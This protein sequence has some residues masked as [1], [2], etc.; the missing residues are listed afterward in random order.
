MVNARCEA[1]FR[2]RPGLMTK[3][4]LVTLDTGQCKAFRMEQSPEF[5]QPRLRALEDWNTETNEPISSLRTERSG[6]FPRESTIHAAANSDGEQRKREL[7]RRRR[8]LKRMASR[9]AELL[10]SEEVDGCCLAASA[11][12]NRGVIDALDPATRERVEKN[13]QANLT[14]LNAPDILQQFSK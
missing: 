13:V 2:A 9:I 1:A 11:E 3:K 4:L 10:G 5:S 8:A 7:E 14:R 6:P 12:I